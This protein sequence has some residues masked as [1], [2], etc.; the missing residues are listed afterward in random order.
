MRRY[1][2]NIYFG[3]AGGLFVGALGPTL[4]RVVDGRPIGKFTLMFCA[5][6]ALLVLVLTV[7][8]VRKARATHDQ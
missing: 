8:G 3:L 1:S 4:G 7:V 2:D 6:A 5:L